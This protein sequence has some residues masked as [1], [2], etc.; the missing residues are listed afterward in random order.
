MKIDLSDHPKASI[1]FSLPDTKPVRETGTHRRKDQSFKDMVIHVNL[2]H[3][4]L[5]TFL[6]M[7][8]TC[9]RSIDMFICGVMGYTLLLKCCLLFI[10]NSYDK[11]QKLCF[12]MHPDGARGS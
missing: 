8:R 1:S 9:L 6:Y 5:Y 2:Y 10:M 3:A 4:A 12:K 7:K 11:V